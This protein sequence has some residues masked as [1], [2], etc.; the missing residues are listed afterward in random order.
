MSGESAKTTS[1]ADREIAS[2]RI[3]NAPRQLVWKVWTNPEHIAQWWGP[4]GFT[5]TTKQ[6]DL[7]PGGKWLFTMHGPDGTDYRNDVTYTAVVEPERLEYD[8]GPTPIFHV[9]VTFDQ[10]GEKKTKLSMQ[11]LFPT[12]EERDRTVE[13]FGAIEGLKQTL[14]RLEEYLA[15]M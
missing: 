14:G 1:V 13:K 3:F 10:E 15:K 11:M 8:H 9:T 7:Q 12:Q 6:F 5:T 2:T 4:I